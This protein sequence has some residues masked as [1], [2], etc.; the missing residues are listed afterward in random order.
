LNKSEQISTIFWNSK[1]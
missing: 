1:F